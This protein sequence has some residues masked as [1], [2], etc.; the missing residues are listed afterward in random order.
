MSLV[1]YKYDENDDSVNNNTEGAIT[2]LGVCVICM[3]MII[4]L[5][6]LAKTAPLLVKKAWV[7]VVDL[8]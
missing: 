6:F 7:G 1:S 2:V 5:Y 8:L 3:V 4:V